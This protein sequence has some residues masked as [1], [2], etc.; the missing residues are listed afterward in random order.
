[1]SARASSRLRRRMTS[2]ERSTRS[3]ASRRSSTDR[4]AS[5]GTASRS[6]SSPA[7]PARPR[8]TASASCLTT[9]SR[10][11]SSMTAL[12]AYVRVSQVRGRSGDSFISPAVQRERIAG[13]AAAHGYEIARTHEELDA[14]GATVDRPKLKLVMER[15]EARETGGVVVL[16]LD[17]FGR[18]LI[19][20]LGLIEDIEH[21]GGTFAS[22]SDGF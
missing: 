22:V 18:T 9:I 12:D 4:C 14:S 19:D 17:R 7:T 6:S 2:A 8:R 13:W 10:T 3:L 11:I 21:A 15:I 5:A 1:M 20:S 16:K